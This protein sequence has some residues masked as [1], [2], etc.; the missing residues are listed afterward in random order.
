MPRARL[1]TPDGRTTEWKSKALRAYQRRTLVADALIAGAYLAGTRRRPCC[2]R[3]IPPRCYSG[4]CLPPARSTCARSMAGR[5]SPQSPSINRLTSQ[6]ETIPSCYRR[7]RHAEFQPHHGR[8]HP[9]TA[10]SE[11]VDTAEAD[12]SQQDG[13]IRQQLIEQLL[14]QI[15]HYDAEFRREEATSAVGSCWTGRGVI[16]GCRSVPPCSDVIS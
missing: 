13:V 1:N 15:M 5:R 6:P 14:R 7:S 10:G 2:H 4:R 12:E 16:C 9:A 11:K 3:Q 8:H